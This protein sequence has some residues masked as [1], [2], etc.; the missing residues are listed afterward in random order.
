MSTFVGMPPFSYPL[1]VAMET[2]YFHIAH[3]NIFKDN[4][5]SHSGGSNEQFGIHDNCPRLQGNLNWMRGK[6]YE[7]ILTH[8]SYSKLDWTLTIS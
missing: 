5:V 7:N 6:S 3:T 1:W 8:T 2:I 4:F